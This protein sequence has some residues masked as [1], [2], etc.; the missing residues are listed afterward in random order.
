MKTEDKV[1]II[2]DFMFTMIAIKD[3]PGV[4]INEIH[5]QMRITYSHL[6]A[7]KKIFVKRGWVN[8]QKEGLSHNLS[9]TEQGEV[10]LKN[11]LA[12]TESLGFTKQ[13]LY[14]LRLKQ[15]KGDISGIQQ[16]GVPKTIRN[17]EEKS[18]ERITDVITSEDENK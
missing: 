2:P 17:E 12:L 10:I 11:I 13:N 7:I 6:H 1:I 4:S 15:K 8:I 5:Y 9:L 3:N 14:D 18:I 16:I